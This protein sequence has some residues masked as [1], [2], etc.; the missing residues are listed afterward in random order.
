MRSPSH[1]AAQ[2]REHLGRAFPSRRAWDGWSPATPG[3]VFSSSHCLSP[4]ICGS[5]Y[6][7]VALDCPGCPLL[8]PGSSKV[9][10]RDPNSV[11]LQHPDFRDLESWDSLL[12]VL[13]QPLWRAVIGRCA[14][15]IFPEGSGCGHDLALYTQCFV[16]AFGAWVHSLPGLPQF[17]S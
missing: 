15:L 16:E 1:P 9:W 12:A 14:F 4:S 13:F 2:V 17:A 8:P 7:Q 6:A 11:Q 5:V 10:L 3:S